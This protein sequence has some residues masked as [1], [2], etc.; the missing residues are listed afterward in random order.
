MPLS[1]FPLIPST[2]NYQSTTLPLYQSTTSQSTNLPSSA[3][4]VTLPVTGTIITGPDGFFAFPSDETAHYWLRV[5]KDGYT[6]GQREADIV[7][8]HSAATNDIYL[9]PIDPAVTLCGSGGCTHESSDGV[10]QVEIP[11]GHPVGRGGDDHRHEF[12]ACGIS[13]ERQPARRD[14]GDVCL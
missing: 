10:L 6:Y 9:T 12:R 2:T 11:A 3:L 5:E 8:R 1:P 14:V 4:T 7:R 13:A